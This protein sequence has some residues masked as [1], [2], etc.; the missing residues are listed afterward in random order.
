MSWSPVKP[1]SSLTGLMESGE[2]EEEVHS[3]IEPAFINVMRSRSSP[4][5]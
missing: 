2:K 1:G 5:L 3:W 4:V